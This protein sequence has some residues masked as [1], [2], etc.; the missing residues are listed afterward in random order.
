MTEPRHQPS[1]SHI[2]IRKRDGRWAASPPPGSGIGYYG[3]RDTETGRRTWYA[4]GSDAPGELGEWPRGVGGFV[5]ACS[6]AR[7]WIRAANTDW[8]DPVW[9]E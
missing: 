6:Q 1:E 8:S 7:C 3:L 4:M 9:D 2:K 5:R